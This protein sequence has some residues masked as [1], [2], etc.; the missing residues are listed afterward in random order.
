L[1]TLEFEGGRVV[2]RGG[3]IPHGRLEKASGAY[4]APAHL[5]RDIVK[6]LEAQGADF[7]DEVYKSLPCPE[8]SSSIQLRGYQRRALDAWAEADHRGVVILPTGAGKTVLAL[9]GIEEMGLATLIIVPTLVL[10]DQWRRELESAFNVEVGVLGGGRSEI[11]A[12]TVATYD[13]ASL[14]APQIGNLF[15]TLV[16]DEVHHLPASSYRRIGLMFSA[17]NRLGLTAT[18]SRDDG[19]RVALMDLVG[20]VVFEMAVDELAGTHLSDYTIQTL[21][22]P[23]SPAE[24]AEYDRGYSQYRDFLRSRGIRIRSARDYQRFVMRSGRDPEARRALLARNRAMDVALNSTRK[25]ERLK[26]LLQSSPD[27]K[28]LIF[29]RHNKL[30]YAISR[31]ML[32]PAITHRTP[33]EERREVLEGFRSGRYMRIVTSQVLDE[34]VDVPDASLAVILSGTGS[35]R[36]FIQRLGRVL[37]KKGGKQARLVELVSMGTA[38]AGLSRRRKGG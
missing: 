27:E 19:A 11:R 7:R 3:P 24:Q 17:P 9:K 15:S 35:S 14:R 16:F 28:A 34:G 22:V 20:E 38:E 21:R 25:V 33:A 13:S 5:Y 1:I 6:Q 37:R 4:V 29:T 36:Q 12:L 26:D 30:V 2:A 18:L 10:V 32:I 8:L 23:L 31:E